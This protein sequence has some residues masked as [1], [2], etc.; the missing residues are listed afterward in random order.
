MSNDDPL[1]RK[2]L[3]FVVDWDARTL[4]VRHDKLRGA[5]KE[6]NDTLKEKKV[7][8]EYHLAVVELQYPSGP[9]GLPMY[10]II[11]RNIKLP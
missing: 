11:A 6:Y 9:N 2:G 10:A 5:V 8:D 1:D 7:G 4:G 3:F